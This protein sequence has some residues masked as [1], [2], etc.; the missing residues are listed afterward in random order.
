MNMRLWKGRGEGNVLM[1]GRDEKR[2]CHNEKHRNL[3]QKKKIG[4]RDEGVRSFNMMNSR[5]KGLCVAD[6]ELETVIII[7]VII[8]NAIFF[9]P[10]PNPSIRYGRGRKE[11]S[12]KR[13]YTTTAAL[14]IVRY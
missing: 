2:S 1:R 12:D 4:F 7:V 8:I 3:A 5:I 14:K 9:L 6:D 13:L 11:N 10:H